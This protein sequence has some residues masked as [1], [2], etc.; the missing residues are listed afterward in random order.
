MLTG[1]FGCGNV[2][3]VKKT[4]RQDIWKR[5]VAAGLIFAAAVTAGLII[6]LYYTQKD[7]EKIIEQTVNENVSM[8]SH[9]LKTILDAQYDYLEGVAGYLGQQEELICRESL[10][11]IQNVQAK[12]G[13][14]RVLISDTQGEAYYDNGNRRNVAERR[15]FQ[16]G[17]SGQ[18]TLS[19][20]LESKADGQTRV[21]LGVPIWKEEQVIGI[22]GGSYDVTA[23]SK[24]MFQ[25][26]Y[27]GEGF[28][29]I[30]TDYL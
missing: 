7:V 15:Y 6:F 23:L 21:V 4:G 14:E 9:Q 25:S 28:S 17:M 1:H 13:L 12:S 3:N 5:Y 11:L 30:L 19:D 10:K 18:R 8:Q 27:D 29:F 20:P 24:M 22:L 2:E 16:E 26:M